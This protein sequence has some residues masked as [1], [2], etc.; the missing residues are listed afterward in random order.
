MK[1]H[2]FK[3]PAVRVR[4]G[5]GP[6]H[7]TWQQCLGLSSSVRTQCGDLVVID[8]IEFGEP[9]CP[10]CQREAKRGP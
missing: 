9:T 2:E 8:A 4:R 5:D 6:W 10:D 3:K 7:G 1:R